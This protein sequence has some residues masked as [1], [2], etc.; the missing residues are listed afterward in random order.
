MSK[1]AVGRASAL[2]S[3]SFSS[4]SVQEDFYTT[5]SMDQTQ[6]EKSLNKRDEDPVTDS[7]LVASLKFFDDYNHRGGR[8]SLREF[9]GHIWL[10]TL[11]RVQR[12]TIPDESNGEADLRSFLESVFDSPESFNI[13]I[14]AAFLCHKVALVQGKVSLDAM[15][16]FAA[17]FATALDDR[18]PIFPDPHDRSL[19]DS[20]SK[21]IEP[22][23]LRMLVSLFRVD[24]VCDVFDQFKLQCTA[25]VVEMVNLKTE[26]SYR[27]R[28]FRSRQQQQIPEPSRP[29][30][31]EPRA[32]KTD[33][34]G[35]KIVALLEESLLPIFDC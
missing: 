31:G 2:A 1:A 11:E 19:N 12:V 22:E 5:F 24:H 3:A 15:Q 18:I 14:E 25:S 33:S 20:F 10:R 17:R 13:R 32:K 29:L 26:K 28:Q 7:G 8:K 16:S 35:T 34:A 23:P 21:G 9:L 6:I 4:T 27:D 30:G